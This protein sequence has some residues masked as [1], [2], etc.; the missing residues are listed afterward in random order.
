[1]IDYKNTSL[2]NQ[3]FALIEKNILTGVY[4][5]G[6]LITEPKLSTELGVS[7]T[8]VREALTR[9]EAERLIKQTPSGML[10]LGISP[11][12]VD[13]MYAVKKAIEPYATVLAIQHMREEELTSLKEI[14]E[15]QEFY[16]TKGNAEKIKDLDTEFHDVIYEASGSPTF[17]S[18]LSPLHHKLMKFRKVSLQ[19]SDRSTQSVEEH[20]KIFAAIKAKDE[21]SAKALML[22]HINNAY[23]NIKGGM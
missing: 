5:A 18:I 22:E 1:M 23:I 19:F 16:V 14:I 8:P 4:P 12:D 7:R 2:A 9:L 6:E 17:A 15:Q 21:E 20:K 3:V 13:E 10:V 11:K